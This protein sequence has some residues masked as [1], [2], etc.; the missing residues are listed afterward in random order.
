M[1]IFLVKCHTGLVIAREITVLALK[2]QLSP[3]IVHVFLQDGLS[4]GRII[5][6]LALMELFSLVQCNCTIQT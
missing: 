6:V 3:M 1:L 4:F 5:T 2:F